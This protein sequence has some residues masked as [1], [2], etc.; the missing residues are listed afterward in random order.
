MYGA[1]RH[2]CAMPASG[3]EPMPSTRSNPRRQSNGRGKSHSVPGKSGPGH[4]GP[5]PG[6]RLAEAFDAVERFPV[7]I[8]SRDR[9]MAAATAETARVGEI[10]EAVESDVALTIAV[11]RFANRS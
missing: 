10:T 4:R 9:V 5:A 1:D 11:M 3:P 6:R 8:E 2:A 7:L